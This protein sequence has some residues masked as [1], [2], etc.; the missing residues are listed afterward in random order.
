M[1]KKIAASVCLLGFILKLYSLRPESASLLLIGVGL[2]VLPE[3]IR[4]RVFRKKASQNICLREADSNESVFF[5][6]K[7][8]C[9]Y[10]LNRLVFY[11][12]SKCLRI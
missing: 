5:E 1:I 11:I 6:I 2:V 12:L 3:F 7:A 8:T 10:I 9:R 4:R